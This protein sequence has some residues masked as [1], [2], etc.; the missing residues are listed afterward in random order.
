MKKSVVCCLLIIQIGCYSVD[1]K[2]PNILF[3][4][5]DDHAAKAISVYD[6]SLIQTPNIDRIAN[7]G[8]RFDNCFCTNS[9]CAPSRAAILTGKYSHI[10]GI[11]DNRQDF[12]G[13]QMT[14]AK[15]LQ[16]AGYTTAIIGKW[17]LKSDPTGFD[18]WNILPGQGSYYN[19]DML[20]LGER[21]RYEGYVTDVITDQALNWLENRDRSK[22]FLMLYQ[23]KAPH[24]NWMPAVR[25]LML[26]N[27]KDLP[28]PDN[29]FDDYTSR[30]DAARQQEMEIGRHTFPAFD[31][32]LN[33]D[34]ADSTDYAFWESQYQRFTP[35]QKTAWDAYY[36]SENK[37]LTGLVPDS[38][39]MSLYK[40]Q[41]YIKDYLRCVI[42][43][44]ENVGRMLDYLE[45]ND[46][47][48][49]TIVIYTSDQGF[50]LGEHGWF[51]KRFMYEEALQMPLMIRY[52]AGIPAQGSDS[53]LVLNIDF[54]PTLLDY[55]GME[56]PPDIQGQSLRKLLSGDPD[57][58][59]RNEIYYHYYEYP[60]WHMVKKHYGMRTNRYKL[61]HFYDDIDAWEL[62]D[63]RKD[64]SEMY[65]IYNQSE[66]K[67]LIDSLKSRL[68][69]LITAYGDTTVPR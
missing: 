8:V 60:G 5:S 62:F 18:Y 21:K 13:S 10:N 53:H 50:F 19:P 16:S 67:L 29:F 48:E 12:D 11:M 42:A 7:E 23:H 1:E 51:D 6:S 47:R 41:R 40:Y 33:P 15:L 25:H 58:D 37:K 45:K 24:R 52:P 69:E 9:I 59:W 56:I 3:I 31:L 30:S 22:P 26:F 43:I 46:L 28:V 27:D 61:I 4:M 68:E 49:N 35:E 54:A 38:P 34:S 65:N 66:N 64:P 39:E 63:L 32:K 14:V 17:H 57:P 55:A 20:E 2:K 36:T 44:D